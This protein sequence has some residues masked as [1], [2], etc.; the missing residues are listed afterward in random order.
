VKTT[1][2]VHHSGAKCETIGLASKSRARN[3]AATVRSI[4]S[5]ASALAIPKKVPRRFSSTEFQRSVESG[6]SST[7]M[8]KE[9]L[10]LRCLAWSGALNADDRRIRSGKCARSCRRIACRG[11]FCGRG[12]FG[13]L[14]QTHYLRGCLLRQAGRRGDNYPSGP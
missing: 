1:N 5:D 10:A 3:I 8:I 11:M 13:Q 4:V 9:K 14:N 6:P 7:M 2:A 12:S